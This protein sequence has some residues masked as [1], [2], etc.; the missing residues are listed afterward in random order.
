MWKRNDFARKNLPLFSPPAV[1]ETNGREFQ[2]SRKAEK[3]EEKNNGRKATRVVVPV[4]WLPMQSDKGTELPYKRIRRRKRDGGG[5]V[6]REAILHFWT[7]FT[8]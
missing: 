3:E 5:W 8:V 4:L 2:I 1:S 6:G 7:I